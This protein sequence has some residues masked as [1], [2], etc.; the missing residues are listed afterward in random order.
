MVRMFGAPC[1]QT[2]A[3]AEEALELERRANASR[4]ALLRLAGTTVF[5]A[6]GLLLGTWLGMPAWKAYVAPCTVYWCGAAL[7]VALVRRRPDWSALSGL[8]LAF[9]DAPIITWAQVL[10]MP[11]FPTPSTVAGF[12]VGLFGM[13]VSMAALSLDRRVTLAVAAVSG[14]LCIFLMRRAEVQLGTQ[15]G[16]MAVLA[17]VAATGWHLVARVRALVAGVAAEGVKR[18]ALAR[19]FS[20]AVAERLESGTSGAEEREVTILFSD[21]RDFT[22]MSERLSPAGVVSLLNEYHAR[23]VE[24]LFRHGGT[25]DKFIG[26]GIMAYFGAPLDAPDHARRAVGCALEMVAELQ[27]LNAAR[28]ARGEAALRIGV[29]IHTG[30]V[31]VG[32][33]GSP[34]RRLE[35]TAIGDAVNLASRLETHTK[36]AGVPVVVSEATKS[37][38][39]DAFAWK[40]LPAAHVKG[41]AEPVPV[42]APSRHL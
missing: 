22:A 12:S 17:L 39:G 6:Q 18:A 14:S 33:I 32:D 37:A 38:A 41:K 23:M 3:V 15:A 7:I 20:P 5:L 40:S 34:E 31:V 27:G 16:S 1:E 24:T 9:L 8:G 21:I 35:Y 25:L 28:V 29:G 36:E 4:M 13:L 19:H 2:P 26:D 42:Y 30:K 10:V 11:L